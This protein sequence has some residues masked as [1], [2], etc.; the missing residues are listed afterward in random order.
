VNPVEMPCIYEFDGFQLDPIQRV[1]RARA[2]GRPV[3]LTARAFDALCLLVERPN[4]LIDK[5]TLIKALWPHVVVEENNLTQ[6]IHALRQALGEKPGENRFIVTVS[7]RGYR[8]SVEVTRRPRSRPTATTASQTSIAVLP[9]A[10][11]TGDVSKDYWGDGM[12]EELIIALSKVPGLKV[13]ARTST[14]AYK[15]RNVDA[16]QIAT[17]LGVTAVLEGSVRSAGDR[18]RISAQLNDATDGFNLWSESYERRLVDL[19]QL[20]DELSGAIVYALQSKLHL[21]GLVPAISTATFPARNVEAYQLY[22]QGRSLLD[23]PSPDNV[24][25][26]LTFFAG[27]AAHDNSFAR[28]YFGIAEAHI[29]LGHSLA[30]IDK[31]AQQALELDPTLAPAQGV[32][33]LLAQC[34]GNWKEAYLCSRASVESDASD[35]HIRIHHAQLQAHVGHLRSALNEGARAYKLAP[36][37]AMVV[38]I[39][40]WINNAAGCDVDALKYGSIAIDLGFPSH[41]WP[42]PHVFAGAAFRAGRR[43]E[44]LSHL[45]AH[46]E[47]CRA[48]D[49]TDRAFYV[50]LMESWGKDGTPLAGAIPPPVVANSANNIFAGY[51]RFGSG[52]AYATAGDLDQAYVLANHCLDQLPQGVGVSPLALVELWTPQMAGFRRDPRFQ[53][54]VEHIG[55]M[56]YYE[57]FGPPDDCDLTNGK[58]TCH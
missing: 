52:C 18:I 56:E 51:W 15:G 7:G 14:F 48:A 12:A 33:A 47:F 10:N 50:H 19:F 42:L 22:L 31:A 39:Y 25:R 23:R 6:T 45:I 17:D 44:A 26:A 1:L 16:R 11:L 36:A 53:R 8:F 34:R 20:Q 46:E 37:S 30:D 58:L 3:H 43:E 54:L 55:L 5:A 28:A 24:G 4:E 41:Q 29:I 13:P 38:A 9:F 49:S 40:A 2:D 21:K 27:A 32:H 35:S 57:E